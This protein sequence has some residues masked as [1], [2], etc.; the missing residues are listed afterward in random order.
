[1]ASWGQRIEVTPDPR[2]PKRIKAT[3]AEW[4]QIR[5]H[6]GDACCV[7]TGLPYQHLHHIAFRRADSGDDV[8]ENLA[9]LTNEAHERLHKRAPGWERV[10]AAIRQYVIVDNARRRYAEDKLGERFN[11]RYPALPNTD[12]QFLAD[13]RAI[14]GDGLDE[15]E[16]IA[17]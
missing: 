9:P 3:K 6:F 10:A 2:P 17:V 13:F 15:I 16:G 5:E 1:M 12:P 11:S 8:I 7:A 14:Y 4:E